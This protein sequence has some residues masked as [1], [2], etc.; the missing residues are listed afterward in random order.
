M[1]GLTRLDQ[2]YLFGNSL[3][4]TISAELG[5]IP[6]LRLLSL[7][8]KQFSGQIPTELGNLTRL[9]QLLLDGNE[10][11]GTIPA[12]LGGGVSGKIAIRLL[13]TSGAN[14]DNYGS[15]CD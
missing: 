3:T 6:N 11:T 9:R 15:R 5:S 2:L 13:D 12:E 7:Y 8:D 14:L 10:L 1:G 4:G